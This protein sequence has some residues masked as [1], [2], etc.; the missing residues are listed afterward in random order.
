MELDRSG[1]R[2]M[3]ANAVNETERH[4]R[5]REAWDIS[6]RNDEG[7][8]RRDFWSWNLG[9]QEE[10]MGRIAGLEGCGYFLRR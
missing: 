1:R 5:K 2:E 6:Q 7:R 9:V 8:I 3:M 4:R 10:L